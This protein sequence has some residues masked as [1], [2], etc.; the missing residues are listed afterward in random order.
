[1]PQH[2]DYTRSRL[3]MASSCSNVVEP[4]SSCLCE[5]KTSKIIIQ[6]IVKLEFI[7]SSSKALTVLLLCSFAALL[8][9]MHE[10]A[11]VQHSDG[12]C[13]KFII[14][15]STKKICKTFAFSLPPFLWRNSTC[16]CFC[17]HRSTL[18]VWLPFGFINSWCWCSGAKPF[19]SMAIDSPTFCKW[20]SYV[21]SSYLLHKQSWLEC[22]IAPFIATGIK[23]HTWIQKIEKRKIP[24]VAIPKHKQTVF[25][26]TREAR[27]SQNF[28]FL[29]AND[30]QQKCSNKLNELD[31]QVCRGKIYCKL[32]SHI[33]AVR[34]LPKQASSD[35]SWVVSAYRRERAKFILRWETSWAMNHEWGLRLAKRF[36]FYSYA[37]VICLTRLGQFL[38]LSLLSSI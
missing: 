30:L 4:F 8:S 3:D 37:C 29:R 15:L 9:I 12:I 27:N 22:R 35:Y 1:M 14:F 2:I 20:W 26:P 7:L 31:S 13:S 17:Q 28:F 18:I 16:A 19:S 11:S 5:I 25:V 6:T 10:K 24:I 21:D 36:F 38:C 33:E 34:K 23:L 32:F